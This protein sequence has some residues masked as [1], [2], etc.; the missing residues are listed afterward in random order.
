MKNKFKLA[1]VLVLGLLSTSCSSMIVGTRVPAGYVGLLINQYGEES[2]RGIENA[3][4]HEGGRVPYN[5]VNKELVLFPTF[6]QKYSYTDDP[7]EQSTVPES[8]KFSVAGTSVGEDIAA[9]VYFDRSNDGKLIKDYYGTYRLDPTEFVR[10][11]LRDEIRGCFNREVVNAGV[12]TPFEYQEKR[13]EILGKVEACVST[14]FPFI[15]VENMEFLGKPEYAENIQASIDEQFQSEQAAK[16]AEARARQATAEAATKIETAKGD[17]EAE[18]IRASL[19]QDPDYIRYR[20]L[21]IEEK[22]IDKWNGEYAPTVQ[23]G[24]VQLGGAVQPQ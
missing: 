20:Q 21:N 8:I 15:K 16:T 24:T 12:K 3:E 23:T 7:N 9:S 6:V 5:P 2:S 1:A 10:S 14:S 11:H 13:I 19:A 22:R 17:V 18:K 4:F